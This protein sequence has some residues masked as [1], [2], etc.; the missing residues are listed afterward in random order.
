MLF[1]AWKKVKIVKITPPQGLTTW[2]KNFQS[3]KFLMLISDASKLI[4]EFILNLAF[5]PYS[6]LYIEAQNSS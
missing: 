6:D 4:V 2:K 5:S 3:A 1:L